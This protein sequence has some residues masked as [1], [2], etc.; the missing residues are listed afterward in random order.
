[1]FYQVC[2]GTA[3][4]LCTYLVPLTTSQSTENKGREEEGSSDAI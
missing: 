4:V 3:P 1:M 2:I